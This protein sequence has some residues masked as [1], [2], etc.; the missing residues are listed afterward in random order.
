M[1]LPI[2]SLTA[3]VT[4][5]TVTLFSNGCGHPSPPPRTTRV[6]HQPAPVIVQQAP[7]VAPAPT[8]PAPQPAV[9]QAPVTPPPAPTPEPLA[10]VASPVS[11]PE[12]EMVTIADTL[13]PDALEVVKMYESGVSEQVI[14]SYAENI[15]EP[16]L[17]SSDQIIYFS[18]IGMSDELI[19]T[20]IEHDR[21][22]GANIPSL[23]APP[24]ETAVQEAPATPQAPV[25]AQS[26]PQSQPVPTPVS[27]RQTTVVVQQPPA[28]STQVFYDS[29]SPYGTWI[30]LDDYGWTWQP[31]VATVNVNWRPYYDSG[32]WVYTDAGWYWN[33]SYSWGWAPFHYGRWS[34]HGSYGWV[35]VPGYRWAPSWV[36]WRYSDAYCGWAPLPPCSDYSVGVGFT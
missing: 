29:L 16:Y 28:V 36:S 25:Y 32:N 8:V 19:Q 5:L 18:D 6:I 35:W 4:G 20:L 9:T 30:Y 1:K 2:S 26:S 34:L 12:G 15:P 17:L 24:V 14:K 21:L 23:E 13:S 22:L 7:P 11:Q 31:T 27:T 33:S 10:P 3:L